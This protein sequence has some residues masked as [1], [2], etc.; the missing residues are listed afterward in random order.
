MKALLTSVCY[1]LFGVT[2]MQAQT[3]LTVNTSNSN[4]QDAEIASGNSANLNYGNEPRHYVYTWTQ[5]GKQVKIRTLL[6]IDLSNLPANAVITNA[7]LELYLDPSGSPATTGDNT[8]WIERITTAWDEN[9]VTW[10]NQPATDTAK[11]AQMQTYN[12]GE[13]VFTADVTSLI[14]TI[15]NSGNNYG[16]MMKLKTESSLRNICFGST[17]NS[18]TLLRPKLTI[19]YTQNTS[20]QHANAENMVVVYPN[21]SQNHITIS[22]PENQNT[23]VSIYDNTGRL[24]LSVDNYEGNSI[25]VSALSTGIYY[26]TLTS[27]DVVR[28]VKFS[29][30]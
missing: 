7:E 14:T 19:I 3:T 1:I 20:V 27:D 22:I 8:F 2:A 12:S 26:A 9:T 24:V 21:P 18:N 13:T 16:F 29:K 30:F 11:R 28:T 23:L 17:E 6:Q 10:N 25:D 4:A 15:K 5:S